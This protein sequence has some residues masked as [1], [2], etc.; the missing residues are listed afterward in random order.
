VC[1]LYHSVAWYTHMVV[2]T[3]GWI[4]SSLGVQAA[5]VEAC[6]VHVAVLGWCPV[7]WVSRMWVLLRRD[8]P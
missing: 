8:V 2:L 5:H 7:L 4:L 6:A 3:R 1:G